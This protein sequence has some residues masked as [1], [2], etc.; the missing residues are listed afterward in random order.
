MFEI[1]LQSAKR[2]LRKRKEVWKC[3]IRVTLDIHKGSYTYL[4]DC[5]FDIIDY[6]SF[7]KS[8]CFTFF[9]YISIRDQ[10]WS[11]HKIGQGQP[12]VIIWTNL[13]QLVYPMQHT[14]FQGHQPFGSREL[15]FLKVFTICGHGG[16]IGHVKRIIWTNFRF[17]ILWRLCMKFG[18]KQPSGFRGEDVWKC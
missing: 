18:F 15:D 16:H 10:I 6:N 13:T 17:P 7:W 14:K 9:P 8:H 12:R 5:N 4:F 11:C 3:W 1:W 2:F